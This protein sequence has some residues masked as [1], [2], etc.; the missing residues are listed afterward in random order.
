MTQDSRINDSQNNLNQERLGK[1]YLCATPIGNLEDITLRALRILKEVDVI[2]AEDTRHTR[3]LMNFYDIHT[4]IT[5]YHEHNEK[6][7][8]QRLILELKDGKN[9]ALVSD[10]GTP[11]ISD[12]GFEIVV[13]AI[14]EGITVVPVPGA[15]AA[16]TAL[17][18]SGLP[19]DRFVFEGFLPRTGKDRE[20]AIKKILSEERTVIFYESPYRVVKTL[21]ELYESGGD[22][23]VAVTRELTKVYE[24]FLRG[25]ISEVLEYFKEHKPK[26]EFTVIVEGFKS[27]HEELPVKSDAEIAE[28]VN[29][30]V[31]QGTDKKSAMKSVAQAI[32]LSKRD[33]Y[34]VLLNEDKDN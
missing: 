34:A 25:T 28:W 7:K 32:G 8:S 4:P 9:I 5:S 10:A 18:A 26:G 19:T 3:K 23:N 14:K 31:E 20:K 13:L 29:K 12:P 6:G 22:R 17:A 33:V 21:E 1:L 15:S 2:A 16:I 27:V 30:L 24:H 11:G